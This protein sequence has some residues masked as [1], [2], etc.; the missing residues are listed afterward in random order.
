MR[1]RM[2]SLAVVLARRRWLVVAAWLVVVV[3]ALPLASRQTENLTGGGF[4]VPGSQSAQVEDSLP[5][6]KGA[7]NGQV[8]A[9]LEAVP[10]T[11]AAA[12]SAGVERLRSAVAEV[13]HFTLP[14]AATAK[15]EGELEGGGVT[16][17]PL[18]SDLTPGDQTRPITM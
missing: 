16:V 10:G 5:H 7:Q 18:R 13:P 11:E 12:A 15:A 3:L 8:S 14:P 9:V 4:D 17:L 6:F 1:A 2:E